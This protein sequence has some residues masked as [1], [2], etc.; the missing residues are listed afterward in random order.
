MNK[1]MKII[2]KRAFAPMAVAVAA[3]CLT[4]CGN[5][6][7]KIEGNITEAADSMLYLENMALDGPQKIDS[8]KL[9]PDG[10]FA[11]THDV[12]TDAPDFY[13][14]RIAQQIVNLAVD[15]T[16]TISVKAAYPTM[17]SDYTIE[18]GKANATIREL[19]LKQIQLQALAK[20]IVEAPEL[21][22][23]T[24]GDSILA[25]VANYKKDV[26]NN[27]IY[28][29]PGDASSYFALFQGIVVGNSY[30]M[31]FD[32]RRDVDDVK[33]FSAVATSW[34]TYHPKSL[35]GENLHNIAIEAMKTKRI[36]QAEQEGL[37]IDA[38]KVTVADIIDIVLPDNKGVT[39][40]LTDL[41]G[42]VV[43][44]DFHLFA[45]EGSMQRI[46]AL[47]ELYTKYH[48][49]GLEIYQVSLDDDEHFWKTQ[50]AALP[51]VSVRDDGSHT[52]TYLYQAQGLPIDYIIS[53]DN[54]VVLGP[55]QIKNL[56]AD[57]AKYL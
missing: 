38:D 12:P 36:V 57:I 52:Q 37:T 30:M 1:E 43:L 31:V 24:V 17:A 26:T 23:K 6:Q 29:R 9:G 25:I 39:R 55:R 20:K 49:R 5:G 28:K 32:P 48:D 41:K 51:W 33:P 46:I 54:E 22:A 11:F 21:N 15:S 19:A 8:V 4:A 16:E 56:E 42:K 45:A 34:D 53:R 44:L 7:F 10:A 35:R 40:R 3:L 2:T 47:R 14:L 18:G 13:R 50:T 27:Y